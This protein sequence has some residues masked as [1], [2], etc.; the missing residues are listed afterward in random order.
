MSPHVSL[1]EALRL[2]VITDRQL[3]APRP[4]EEVVEICLR[5]GVR[6]VQLRDKEASAGERTA[7]PSTS[8]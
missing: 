1:R 7:L 6:A 4:V 5:A 8:I 2:I 3:A